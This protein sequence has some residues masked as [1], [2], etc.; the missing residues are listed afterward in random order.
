M[1]VIDKLM[2][3]ALIGGFSLNG[4][5]YLETQSLSIQTETDHGLTGIIL[6]VGD[7]MGLSQISSVYQTA[8]QEPN[9]SKFPVVGLSK[10]G[11]SSHRITDS[12]AGATAFSCGIKTYNGAI[13]LD[14]DSVS[15]QNLFE[16]LSDKGW[17]T[18]IVATSS[19]THATPASFYAHVTSRSMEET[20]AEQ[21][22][23][24]EL[25]YVAGGG[26]AWFA[27]RSDS[28]NYLDS[29]EAKGFLVDTNRI[30]GTSA[31]STSKVCYLIAKDGLPPA[32]KG[33]GTFLMDATNDALRYL[34]SKKQPFI[35]MVES[36]Q[37]DWAGHNNDADY[38]KAEML[39]FNDVIGNIISFSQQHN[40]LV[41]TTADHE[42]GGLA[43]GGESKRTFGGLVQ[44]DYRK[45]APTFSTLGHTASMV[46]VFAIGPGSDLFSGIYENTQIYYRL[47]SLTRG[48]E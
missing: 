17:N 38:L 16:K 34:K 40:L 15:V 35:L 4:C 5:S 13:G 19:V 29:L 2:A 10:T 41:V 42:T 43:L 45:V 14:P 24:S 6:V 20:I 33:R 21:L 44:N 28:I 36:S 1:R 30:I 39:E 37:I 18:G 48:V 25:D 22:V 27:Q 3:T 9:F 31:D 26:Y 11:S 7:G 46:P 12:A 8:G 47:D 23:Y 32:H